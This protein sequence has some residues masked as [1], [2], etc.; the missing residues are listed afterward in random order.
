MKEKTV[1][2]EVHNPAVINAINIV[3]MTAMEGKG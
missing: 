3:N 1:N 2:K